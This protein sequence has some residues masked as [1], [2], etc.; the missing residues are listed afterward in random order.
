[1]RASTEGGPR[2][3]KEPAVPHNPGFD[4]SGVV[5]PGADGQ[6]PVVILAADFGHNRSGLQLTNLA[7]KDEVGLVATPE[8]GRFQLMDSSGHVFFSQPPVP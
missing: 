8:T 2:R 6:T 7:L 1:M 3:R 5:I 4:A